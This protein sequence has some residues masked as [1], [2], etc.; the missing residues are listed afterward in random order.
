MIFVPPNTGEPLVAGIIGKISTDST[1]GAYT[2]IE[3]TL[4]AGGGAPLHTHQ[5]EDEIFYILDGVCEVTCD[6]KTHLAEAGAMVVLP[7]HSLHAFR[8]V[9]DKPNRILITA[10]P[11]GLDHYFAELAQIRNDDPEAGQKVADINARYQILF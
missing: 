7:K 10:V 6:G 8:N 1:G 11:G 3:L 9:G 2:V 4:P 5:R